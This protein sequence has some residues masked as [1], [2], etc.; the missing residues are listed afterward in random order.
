MENTFR[1]ESNLS[2]SLHI[3]GYFSVTTPQ[4]GPRSPYFLR[5][6]DHRIGHT[7]PVQELVAEGANCTAH[8]THKNLTSM[9]SLR[10]EPTIPANEQPQTDSL[11]RTITAIDQFYDSVVVR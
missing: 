11:D 1:T 4:I 2:V 6:P 9:P 5:A 3:L 7:H 8:N 10:L